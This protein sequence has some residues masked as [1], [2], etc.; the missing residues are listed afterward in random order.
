MRLHGRSRLFKQHG[1]FLV[2]AM[3]LL[4]LLSAV[5]VAIMSTATASMQVSRNYAKYLQSRLTS[6]SM[7][8]YG[9]RILESFADGVYF[10]P[11]TCSS[12]ATCNIIYNTFP[13]NGR[14]ILP[15]SSGLSGKTLYKSSETIA[16]WNANSFAYEASFGGSVTARVIVE[17]VGANHS[18]PYQNTYRVVGF[19]T[20][21]T[22]VVRNTSQ[23]FH[24]WNAYPDD[25]GD[26]TCAGKCYYS[27]CCSNTN[28]CATDATSCQNGSATYVPPGWTCTDF[29]VTGLGYNSN[30]CLFPVA[31]PS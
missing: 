29:F 7:A 1:A 28:S 24:V 5:G 12:A 22:G 9:N 3:I 6:I 13:M 19:A 26:G 25:P 8:G 30:A 20:D 11:G 15:W 16:W 2:L 18:S 21:S 10:G 4:I 14:P 17:L 23:V 27:Q 31:P